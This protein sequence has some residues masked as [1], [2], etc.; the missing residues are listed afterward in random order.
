MVDQAKTYEGNS[1]GEYWV[2]F[3]RKLDHVVN[4]L[5]DVFLT[6]APVTALDER[7]ALDIEAALRWV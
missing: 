6:I 4:E 7:V 1:R 5:V 2:D 3:H